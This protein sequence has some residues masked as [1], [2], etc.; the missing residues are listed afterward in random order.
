[1]V[2]EKICPHCRNELSFCLHCGQP[3]HPKNDYCSEDC[4]KNRT[5]WEEKV[6]S[7]MQEIREEGEIK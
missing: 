3:I 1:M 2:F 7:I 4:K 5:E 6:S